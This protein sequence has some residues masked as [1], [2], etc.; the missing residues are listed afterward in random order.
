M[1]TAIKFSHEN[2]PQ[3]TM[4]VHVH[5]F[6]DREL[7]PSER[8]DVC[9]RCNVE[10]ECACR[11]KTIQIFFRMCDV[12]C[13]SYYGFPLL[14][15]VV[16]VFQWYIMIF[17]HLVCMYTYYTLHLCS[18]MGGDRFFQVVTNTLSSREHYTFCIFNYCT[19]VKISHLYS[20]ISMQK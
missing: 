3:L 19:H 1:Y 17:R 12:K 7:P 10:C 15:R 16:C 9:M 8:V 5:H 6:W 20:I 14:G 4:T 18:D 2:Y 13:G 11:K